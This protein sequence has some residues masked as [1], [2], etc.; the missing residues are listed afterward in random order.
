MAQYKLKYKIQAFPNIHAVNWSFWACCYSGTNHSWSSFTLHSYGINWILKLLKIREVKL[1]SA[2]NFSKIS[3]WFHIF[4]KT[5]WIL[6]NDYL[7]ADR[8]SIT[9]LCCLCINLICGVQKTSR[10]LEMVGLICFN[11][12]L[13]DDAMLIHITFIGIYNHPKKRMFCPTKRR[14]RKT[15]E[16]KHN[17]ATKTFQGN[18]SVEGVN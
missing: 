9:R 5:K 13:W 6:F 12:A 11:L 3:E 14:N 7:K 17:V 8:R 4:F 10:Q 15:I 2:Y 18:I 1:I 16:R